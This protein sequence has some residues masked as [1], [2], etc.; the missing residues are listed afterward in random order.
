LFVRHTERHSS[1]H[2]ENYS[3]VILADPGP[4]RE[5]NLRGLWV[6]DNEKDT[7]YLEQFWATADDIPAFPGAVRESAEI[8]AELDDLTL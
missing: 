3:A 6:P 4:E 5:S 2:L 1:L 8:L 7:T